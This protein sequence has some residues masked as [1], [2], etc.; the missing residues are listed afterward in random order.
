MSRK[1][2]RARYLLLEWK[3]LTT[4]VFHAQKGVRN[5]YQIFPSLQTKRET[6]YVVENRDGALA[7]FTWIERECDF[8]SHHFAWNENSAKDNFPHFSSFWVKNLLTSAW[9]YAKLLKL[10]ESGVDGNS[11]YR[12]EVKHVSV[13]RWKLRSSVNFPWTYVNS[14]SHY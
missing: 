14:P 13:K 8:I 12:K 4:E 1:K 10:L 2:S 5:N 11:K 6:K 9:I 7:K 3:L